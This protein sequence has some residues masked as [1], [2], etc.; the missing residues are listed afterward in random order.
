[1]TS[2]TQRVTVPIVRWA[3]PLAA[4]FL[5]GPAV[6]M[7]TAWMRSPDGGS[8][9]SPLLCTEP[10]LGI[11]SALLA[12]VVATS[13]GIVA[14]RIVDIRTG[15]LVAGFTLAWAALRTGELGAIVRPYDIETVFTRLAI[16]GAIVGVVTAFAAALLLH[17][18]RESK[19]QPLRAANSPSLRESLRSVSTLF[20]LIVGLLAATAVA[21]LIARTDAKAQTI[22]AGIAAGIAASAAGKLVAASMGDDPPLEVFFVSIALAAV[23]SPIVVLVL[24]GSGAERDLFANRLFAPALILPLD[25]AAGAFI[26]VPIGARWVQGSI[27]QRLLAG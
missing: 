16:E 4:L 7:A 24:H 13:A 10:V 5:L 12:I 8:D 14:G 19:E 15:S 6:G 20:A 17:M 18:S 25:W 26:G 2:T 22:V 1:M 23:I 9:A 3:L 11:A 27:E 21:W